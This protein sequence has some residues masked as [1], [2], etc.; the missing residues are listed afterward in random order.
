MSLQQANENSKK[1]MIAKKI[2]ESNLH[3]FQEL[4][5]LFD[6]FDASNGKALP[7]Q[8]E[9]EVGSKRI[10]LPIFGEETPELELE[11]EIEITEEDLATIDEYVLK[12]LNEEDLEHIYNKEYNLLSNYATE[13]IKNAI[14]DSS[15]AND[16][17]LQHLYEI[18]SCEVESKNDEK[19]EEDL[20]EEIY[21]EDLPE[22]EFD[23]ELDKDDFSTL[24]NE[25]IDNESEEEFDEDETGFEEDFEEHNLLGIVKKEK[26]DPEEMSIEK[27]KKTTKDDSFKEIDDERVKDFFKNLFKRKDKNSP[28]KA[29]N[30]KGLFGRK[31]KKESDEKPEEEKSSK[32]NMKDKKDSVNL[33]KMI[34]IA[35]PIVLI[36]G[37]AFLFFNKESSFKSIEELKEEGLFLDKDLLSLTIPFPEDDDNYTGSMLLHLTL[38]E[39]NEK[40]EITCESD[41]VD[42]TVGGEISA[43]MNCNKDLSKE[44]K[45]K[46][47]T[48]ESNYF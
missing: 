28:Q 40:E 25:E 17:V 44:K 5:D 18:P 11:K 2:S 20:L 19:Q 33:K 14:K 34:G 10:T 42:I 32:K 8:E 13:L 31:G 15:E 23:E 22:E 6:E 48:L 39:E 12:K 3:S 29:K 9:L 24:T 30:K 16:G 37:L 35:I 36:L 47:K 43:P 4:E 7:K 27:P 38:E 26:S 21:D 46:I 1:A 45:Y 41:I